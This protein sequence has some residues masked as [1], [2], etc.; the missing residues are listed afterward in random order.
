VCGDGPFSYHVA[1]LLIHVCNSMLVFLVLSRLLRMAGWNHSKTRIASVAGTLV[2]LVHPLETES[3][4]YIAGRSESLASM[5]LLLAYVVF[6]Y[7][8]KDEISWVEALLVIL[9]F[10]MGVKTKENAV[11]LAGILL[12]T[13]LFWPRPVPPRG[14][15]AAPAA[16]VPRR[17]PPWRNWRLYVLMLPGVAVAAAAVFR[18]L[19]TAPSAGFS[20]RTFTW[21]EYAFT[22]A[23]AIFVYIRMALVPVG[24]SIDHDFATSHTVLEHGAIFWLVLVAA[25]VAASILWRR[26]YPLACF[27]FLMFLGWLA[28]TSSVVPINDALVERRMYLA[29]VGL[30]LVGCEIGGRL[31]LSRRACYTAFGIMLAVFSGFCYARNRLYGAPEKLFEAAAMESTGNAR[32]FASLADVA[33]AENRCAIAVPYLQRAD[34]LFPHDYPVEL[35][36]GRILECLGRRDE[37]MRRLYRA[38]AIQ[39]TS[40]VYE[41]IGLLY[42]EMGVSGEAG[43]ALE[44]AVKLDPNSTTAHKA[45]ALWYE[46]V[47]DLA[48]SAR[49]YR[50]SLSLDAN[51]ENARLSLMRVREMSSPE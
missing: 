8:R 50:L 25:L 43:A 1:N 16:P 51:D 21:Y 47:H 44:E 30:I 13:D 23:R 7:R 37:A 11:S 38:A 3:V 36:W 12:L 18:M 49:E 35:S 4:S 39:R 26:R 14:S 27:G 20:L 41:L 48:A 31:R 46:S 9:L 19:L 15:E 40:K 24:Q 6:L 17:G 34:R 5:F 2:F 32:P 42:G 45:L 29:L 10:A 28:P 22:E 33:I